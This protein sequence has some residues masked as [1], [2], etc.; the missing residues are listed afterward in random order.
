MA[1]T[2]SSSDH[3]MVGFLVSAFDKVAAK[4][5]HLSADETSKISNKVNVSVSTVLSLAP[6]IR[7]SVDSY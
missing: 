1:T 6:R 3:L 2:P 7:Y 5:N 4:E